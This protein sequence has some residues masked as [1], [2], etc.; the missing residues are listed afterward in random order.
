[1]DITDLSLQQKEAF[2]LYLQRKNIFITGAGGCGKTYFIR[3]IYQHAKDNH[4]EIQVCATTGCSALLLQCNAMTIHSWAGIGHGNGELDTYIY[5][6]KT[7]PFLR[8]RW[9]KTK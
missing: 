6:I 3:R 2:D 7:R 8:N 4:Q 1:M 9:L 5:R